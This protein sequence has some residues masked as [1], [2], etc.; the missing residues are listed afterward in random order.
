VSEPTP[1]QR[2]YQAGRRYVAACRRLEK[3]T[4]KWVPLNQHPTVARP[5][6][7]FAGR[8]G[9]GDWQHGF[10]TAEFRYG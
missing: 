6:N 10:S 4:P 2:G 5:N 9:E 3:A 1:Y 8:P 7:P